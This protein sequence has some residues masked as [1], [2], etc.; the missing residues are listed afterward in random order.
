MKRSSRF[1]LAPAVILTVLGFSSCTPELSCESGWCGTLVVSSPPVQSLFPPQPQPLD[2]DLGV[3]DLIFSK[4]ADVGP[5]FNTIGDT[6]F[7]NDLAGSWTFVDDLTLSIAL[8]PSARWHDGAPVTA[9]DVVYTFGVYQDPVVNSGARSRLGAIESVTARDSLTVVFRFRYSYPEKFY[10]AVSHVHILPSHL[11]ESV[12]PADLRSHEFALHPTGSGPYKVVSW[13]PGELV[14]LA[15]D[16]NHFLGRPG[17]PRIIWSPV[18]QAPDAVNELVADRADFVYYVPEQADMERVERSPHL[19]LVEYPSNTYNFVG[20][21]L[22]DPENENRPHALF[23]DRAL[24]RAVVMAVNRPALRQSVLGPYTL[25]SVGPVTPALRIWDENLP[26]AIP[27]D[28]AGARTAL[29]SLG[30]SDSDG[31]GILDKGGRPLE[32]ELLVPPSAVRVRGAVILQDQLARS[33]IQMHIVEIEW[34]AFFDRTGRG[35]FDAQYSSLGQDPSPAALATDWTEDGF[36]EFNWGKYSDPEFTRLVREARDDADRE[37]SLTKW[38]AALRIINE[39]APAIWLY[40]PRKFAAVHAR[41]DDVLISPYQ[42]WIGLPGFNVPPTRLI[43][44]D[45]YGIN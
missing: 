18:F 15:A 39:D 32:F 31:D 13:T 20:F 44:R 35:A 14:E 11:L 8:N 37:A 41:F 10:D 4:L 27:F 9:Q 17:V 1:V 12:A 43:E 22:R 6:D 30:W 38:H 7:V 45:L 2:V 26:E 40:V 23:G 24:R 25:P 28:S 34:P 33:G 21:N 5:S 42:P 16:S 36:T 3:A 29:N 19:R